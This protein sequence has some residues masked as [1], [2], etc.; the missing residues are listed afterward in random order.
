MKIL[1][2][3][4]ELIIREWLKFVIGQLDLTF[5]A[6]ETAVSGEEALEVCSRIQPEIIFI[7]IVM[8][9]MDGLQLLERIR[10]MS[11][12]AEIVILT[13]HENFNFVRTAIQYNVRN[14]VLKTE[15]NKEIIHELLKGIQER[16]ELKRTR[17]CV[18]LDLISMSKTT[19]LNKLMKSGGDFSIT[20]DLLDTYMIPLKNAPL[21]ALAFRTRG[22][23]E[24][25]EFIFPFSDHITNTTGFV[26][27]E[28]INVLVSNI[29]TTESLLLQMQ[30]A[31]RFANQIANQNNFFIGMSRI[32]Y[33][34]KELKH[35]VCEAVYHLEL[36]FYGVHSAE[37]DSD[38]ELERRQRQIDEMNQ[39]RSQIRTLVGSSNIEELQPSF[40]KFSQLVLEQAFPDISKL[41]QGFIDVLYILENSYQGD[42][43]RQVA[44]KEIE[45]A[46]NF[47]QLKSIIMEYVNQ[48]TAVCTLADRKYSK[49][50]K[51]TIQYILD[52]VDEDLRLGTVAAQAGLN[53]E[54]FSRLF[55][56]ETGQTFVSF[57]CAA[58]MDW[59]AKLLRDSDLRVY[60][61][62]EMAG[63]SNV[64]YFSSLFKARY[65]VNPFNYKNMS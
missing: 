23:E 27:N 35:A 2:V 29:E 56:K 19:F 58:K 38:K 9:G 11:S 42:E 16:L 52:H 50:V 5:E 63:Y 34:W 24:M 10:G 8:P 61:V 14:Y 41:K 44:V 4:D 30:Y 40:E 31:S 43:K 36:H 57:V 28:D 37:Y 1:I 54:Y 65:G 62:A 6:I 32:K 15:I 18:S 25:M 48:Y 60:E 7:D 55:K 13:S 21:F 59:A 17:R 46:E 33:G 26:Y 49:P 39:F 47:P 3:D 64:G 51:R 22:G 12:E 53:P 45:A 20:R